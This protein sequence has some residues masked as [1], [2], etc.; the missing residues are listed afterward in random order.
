MEIRQIFIVLVDISGY[1]RFLTAHRTSLL[2]AEYIIT[3]LLKLII[4]SSKSPLVLHELEGDAVN[5]YAISDGSREMA[6]D[7]GTQVLNFVGAFRVR[8]KEL[9]SEC[10]ACNCEACQSIGKLKMKAVLHHGEAAFTK[11]RNFEKIGSEDV[12]LAHRLLKNS[13]ESDEYILLS[14]PFAELCE[15]LEGVELEDRLEFCEGIGEVDVKVYHT[16]PAPFSA[17]AQRPTLS[18]LSMMAKLGGYM[19][20]RR[21]R[22]SPEFRHLQT[23]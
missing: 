11:I 6:Q 10:E 14:T 9:V 13:I 3:E 21:F 19:I 18:K 4:E 16:E 1:T 7:I 8:E 5:F 2:H 23:L 20:K 17:P 22:P 12:I 15:D